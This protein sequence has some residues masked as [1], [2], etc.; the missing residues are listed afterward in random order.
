MQ[1]IPKSSET[2]YTQRAALAIALARM[3][4][5]GGG[6][7]GIKPANVNAG[8]WA[9]LYIDL[10]NGSQLSFHISQEDDPLLAGLPLYAGE[11]DGT[12][13]GRGADWLEAIPLPTQFEQLATI[14]LAHAVACR[15][16]SGHA[17][18]RWHIEQRK[19]QADTDVLPEVAAQILMGYAQRW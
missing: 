13:L 3:T 4:L 15:R 16:L 14:E 10:P 6:R 12:Y 17:L 8:E 1:D 5:M 2:I 19:L 18:R 9:V 7:A 11:W